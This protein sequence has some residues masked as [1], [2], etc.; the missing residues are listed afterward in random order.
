MRATF[1]P[2]NPVSE[3]R[4]LHRYSSTICQHSTPS[5]MDQPRS[6]PKGHAAAHLFQQNVQ[7][8]R[9]LYSTPV[10]LPIPLFTLRL[11]ESGGSGLFSG[12]TGPEERCVLF[13]G[14]LRELGRLGVEKEV[15]EDE[16]DEEE[17][18]TLSED[19]ALGERWREGEDIVAHP[20]CINARSGRWLVSVISIRL[21]RNCGHPLLRPHQV[22]VS[23]RGGVGACYEDGISRSVARDIKIAG[24]RTNSIAFTLVPQ[25]AHHRHPSHATPVRPQIVPPGTTPKHLLRKTTP[26]LRRPPRPCLIAPQRATGIHLNHTDARRGLHRRRSDKRHPPNTV[27]ERG[28]L[29]LEVHKDRWP[30][31]IW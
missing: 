13:G 2:S 24:S 4:S 31:G 8:F 11:K 3:A 29:R 16:V 17:D 30:H 26:S 28:S 18:G 23:N 20:R 21:G 14:F 5:P 10:P 7:P 15:L 27:P 22:L 9:R 1:S 12:E 19:E 6:V 25:P